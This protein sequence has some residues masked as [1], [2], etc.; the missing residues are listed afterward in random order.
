VPV[1][2]GNVCRVLGRLTGVANHIKAAVFKDDL[3]WVLAEKIVRARPESEDDDSF[4]INGYP[5]E[6]RGF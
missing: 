6:V 5:G 3:G 4:E 1:V 2:D